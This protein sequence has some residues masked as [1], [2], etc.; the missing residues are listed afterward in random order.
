MT[1]R[2]MAPVL[3]ALN[4]ATG[5]KL[6]E[7]PVCEDVPAVVAAARAAQPSWEARPIRERMRAL[8]SVRD[9]LVARQDEIA[10]VI[11]RSTGKPLLEAYASEVFPAAQLLHTFGTKADGWLVRSPRDLSIMNWAG[12]RSHVEYRAAGTVAVIS[13]WN[14]PFSIPVGDIAI[15]L[16]AGC[17]IVLKPSEAVP[18]VGEEIRKLF[19]GL[20][21]FIAQGPGATGAGLIAARPD[22]IVF[23]G[24]GVAARKVMEAASKHLVPV[25]MELGGKDPM[26]VRADADLDLAGDAAVWGCFTNSG[27]VCA[28][29]KRIFVARDVAAPFIERVVARTK[30]LRQGDPFDPDVDIGSMTVPMQLARVEEQVKR[31]VSDGARVL[32]GGRRLDRPGLFF[33]PTVLGDVKPDHAIM[34]EECF[35][36][37]LPILPVADD[38]EAVR[39]ANDSAFGL[40]AS[41]WSKDLSRARELAR[42]IHA[43]TITINDTTYTHA[44]PETPWGGV[45]ESGF[46]RTHGPEGLLE[47]VHAVHVNE[48]RAHHRRSLWWFPYSARALAIFRAAPRALF[49]PGRWQALK[50]IWANFRFGDLKPRR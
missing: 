35:G 8:L 6:G 26:I 13:P 50:D 34:R 28:S 29:V 44:L 5:E 7:V 30:A 42:R 41:V 11:T 46:G 47:F 17:A 40:C 25:V 3:E 20:P 36:P 9:R 27:Q 37:I 4:P 19:E 16:V 12:R 10:R 21:V 49:G 33:Q 39:L 43:G 45:K 14:Y 38:D 23:T 32:A 22:K 15:G 31:A 24:G 2:V 1:Q 18:L 48:N